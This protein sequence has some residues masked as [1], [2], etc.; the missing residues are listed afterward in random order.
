[1][2]PGGVPPGGVSPLTHSA[3]VGLEGKIIPHQSCFTAT[4][5]I[6]AINDD[7]LPKLYRQTELCVRVGSGS[8]PP[9]T[10]CS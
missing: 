8:M 9:L 7:A 6:F 4:H 10:V 2:P 1:M 5:L 3:P